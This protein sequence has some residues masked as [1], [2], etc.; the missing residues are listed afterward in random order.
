L[1]GTAGGADHTG[2]PTDLVRPAVPSYRGGVERFVLGAEL[3]AGLQQ[4][5]R[6]EGVTL[7]MV[8][9]AAFAV[10]LGRYSSHSDIALGSPVAS[11]DRRELEGLIGFFVNTLVMRV[12][13]S[14]EPTFRGLLQRV[15]EVALGRTSTRSCRSRSW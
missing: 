1:A 15:R 6:R 9:L 12:D 5:A 3:T 11:R 7:Y 14:G 2:L 10:L 8:L 13:L 4:L